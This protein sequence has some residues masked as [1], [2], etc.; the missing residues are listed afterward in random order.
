ME[1]DAKML[2][3]TI[4]WYLLYGISI[5]IAAIQD[6]L[7]WKSFAP[8][9]IGL[10]PNLFSIFYWHHGGILNVTV[11]ILI[12]LALTWGLIFCVRKQ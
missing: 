2:A 11:S 12:S 1:T 7:N 3:F 10:I 9:F 6:S 4:G 8:Y 5:A